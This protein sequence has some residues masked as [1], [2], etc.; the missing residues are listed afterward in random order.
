MSAMSCTYV[1]WTKEQTQGK[2]YTI[3]YY[4]TLGGTGTKRDG[5]VHSNP[6]H[7]DCIYFHVCCG[8]VKASW[9]LDGGLC[10]TRID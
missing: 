9:Q 3:V 5:L 1:P 2:H 10:F 4:Y 8:I 6:L 7:I